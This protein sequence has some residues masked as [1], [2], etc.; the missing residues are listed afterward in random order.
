MC[1][2]DPLD[3]S[4]F[5]VPEPSF[6]IPF[7]GFA[8]QLPEIPFPALP[9]LPLED[10]LGLFDKL[11]FTLPSGDLKP[12]I[13][14]NFMK[15]VLDGILSLLEK[16]IPFFM[17]YKFFMPVLNIILCI[18]D[19]LC[20]IP[21][22]PFSIGKFIRAMTRLFRVCIP[23]FLAL[24][25]PIAIIIMILSLILLIIA[26]IIYLIERIIRMIL[27]LIQNI[28]TLAQAIA[29]FDQDSIGAIVKKIGDLLCLFQNLFVIL[30]AILLIIKVIKELLTLSFN[31]PPCDD[32]DSSEDGCCTIDVCPGFIRDN[33]NGITHSTG[34]LQYLN[35]IEI[36]SGLD[37]PDGFPKITA[38]I[39]KESW[40]FYDETLTYDVTD[41]PYQAFKNII[42]PVETILF[43][44]GFKGPVLFLPSA[45]Y[46]ETVATQS[47]PYTVD[48]RFF[49]DPAGFNRADSLGP[50]FIQ[51]KDCTVS[52]IPSIGVKQNLII[53]NQT[54]I[55]L[56]LNGT[57]DL[58][59]GLAVEDDGTTLLNIGTSQGT[60]QTVIHLDDRTT[61]AIPSSNDQVK[62][63]DITYTFKLN[64]NVLVATGL[65]SSSCAPTFA[66]EKNII[67]SVL[68]VPLQINAAALQNL[69]LP[70]V[71]A[72]R[73]CVFDALNDFRQNISIDS[74]NNF[75]DT[76]INCLN[77]LKDQCTAAAIQL[78]DIG[79]DQNK[80]DF[81]IDPKIQFTTRPINVFVSLNDGG[82]SVISSALTDEIAKAVAAKIKADITFGEITDFAYD[83]YTLFNAKITSEEPG[84]GT[85]QVSFNDK[86]I[87]IF[88]NPADVSQPT[89]LNSKIL[90]YTFVK[91]TISVGDPAVRRNEGDL[92]QNNNVD[93]G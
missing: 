87:S 75:Q 36:D 34:Q 92:A 63:T 60:L 14:A 89:S 69:V 53:A 22:T 90:S 15:D 11:K 28:K 76:V 20:N 21:P 7:P 55:G 44:P 83:G 48:L 85:I 41:R 88:D 51:I 50:R 17:L 35:K 64:F 58:V 84:N 47:V 24:I 68:A 73:T 78:I 93:G 3:L 82:G 86:V 56:P 31:I 23:E 38:V 19:I 80:S 30:G 26:L 10:L 37:L 62:I 59:G 46:D 8:P 5:N 71:E 4:N 2:C 52:K 1:P 39:R 9:S 66:K 16:F 12:S 13:S 72:A 70:D 25:P 79:Y 91:S 42:Q 61:N 54:L 74:A 67:N 32:G 43:P 45:V 40:Q 6:N 81:S 29:R 57:L 18:I 77:S 27:L 33:E 49:Y 65:V